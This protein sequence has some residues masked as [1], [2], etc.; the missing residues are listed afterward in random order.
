M[1]DFKDGQNFKGSRHV[2]K[3][4]YQI[5]WLGENAVFSSSNLLI[6]FNE[7]SMH[8]NMVQNRVVFEV[9]GIRVYGE[10]HCIYREVDETYRQVVSAIQGNAEDLSEKTLKP[11]YQLYDKYLNK[12]VIF[13]S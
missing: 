8:L 2:Y 6:V 11:L 10:D 7:V 1:I 13:R 3:R 5:G 4:E 9:D 12:E